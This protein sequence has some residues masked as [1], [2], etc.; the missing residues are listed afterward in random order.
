MQVLSARLPCVLLTC[1]CLVG[2]CSSCLPALPLLQLTGVCETEMGMCMCGVAVPAMGGVSQLKL[3]GRWLIMDRWRAQVIATR[4]NRGNTSTRWQQHWP[5]GRHPSSTSAL[6][7]CGRTC[8]HGALRCFSCA[9]GLVARVHSPRNV[10]RPLSPRAFILR[11]LQPHPQ[12]SNLST[13]ATPQPT[14]PSQRAPA[15][16]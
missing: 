16:T 6:R 10:G 1:E 7:A 12:A 13:P 2:C 11:L 8:L 9:Y 14:L 15:T 3:G 5:G 4:S